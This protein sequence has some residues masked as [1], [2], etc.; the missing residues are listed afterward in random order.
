MS[1]GIDQRT[2]GYRRRCE[3]VTKS[4]EQLVPMVKR[5]LGLG[6]RAK[7]VLMDS[8]FSMPSVIAGLRQHIHLICMRKAPPKWLYEY[9]DRKLRLSEFI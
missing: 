2:C 8:W 9:Q 6:V 3:A 7:Y 1:S 5:A 4:T